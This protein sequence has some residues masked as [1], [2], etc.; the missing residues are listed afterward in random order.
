MNNYMN[1]KEIREALGSGKVDIEAVRNI[2]YKIMEAEGYKEI[3]VSQNTRLRTTLGCFKW[4][5]VGNRVVPAC[6]EFSNAILSIGGEQ[7]L[8]TMLHELAHYFVTEDTGKNNGHNSRW[9]QYAEALGCSTEPC[10]RLN[11]EELKHVSIEKYKYKI[12]CATCGEVV[13]YR[14]RK[15]DLIK[16]SHL[17][18]TSCCGG[19]KIKVIKL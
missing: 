4:V 6:I 11:K 15:S 14:K 9:E 7:L 1:N 10:A 16:N 3:E 19:S 12:V 17:Y 2:C 13:E 18:T 5:T 8:D